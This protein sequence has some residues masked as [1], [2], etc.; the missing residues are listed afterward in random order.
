MIRKINVSR[1]PLMTEVG[2]CVLQ[3][4][5]HKY[6]NAFVTQETVSKEM[7]VVTPFTCVQHD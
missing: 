6:F 4:Q 2:G 3:T 7:Q 5:Y 1:V